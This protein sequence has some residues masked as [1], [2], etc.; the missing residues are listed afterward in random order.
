M[1]VY[2]KNIPGSTRLDADVCIIGGGAAG[3]TI[4]RSLDGG[5]LKVLLV[6]GGGSRETA[7]TTDLYTGVVEPFDTHE[8]LQEN[9]VRA[10][11]GSTVAWGGRCIPYDAI[12]FRRRDW[13]PHSGWPLSYDELLP[14]IRE[15]VGVCEA[16]R[17]EFDA[18]AAFPGTQAEILAGIDGD[19]MHSWP[20]ERW[21]PPTNF[22]TRYGQGFN[23]SRNVTVVLEGHVVRL[24]VNSTGSAVTHAVVASAP[25]RVFEVRAATFVLAAGG[26]EN[27]RLLLASNDVIP[28]GLGNGHDLVGRFYQSHRFGVC[29]EAVLRDPMRN[30]VY[31]FE[32]DSDGVYC[33]RRFRLSDTAQEQHRI[34]NAIA[35]FARP[36]A[37]A[38]VHRNA[39]TSSVYLAKT[40]M[41]A[42][43]RGPI[44][45]AQHL[46]RERSILTQHAKVVMS[47]GIRSAP[48]LWSLAVARFGGARRL[49]SILPP[50]R[51]NHFHL[52][53]QTEHAPN[54]ESRVA[55]ADERDALGMR[56]LSVHVAFS[57]V[58]FDTVRQ[59]Y[60]VFA[61]RFAASGAGTFSYSDDALEQQL[62]ATGQGFNSNAHHIGTTRMADIPSNGVVDRDCR[63]HGMQNLFVS[64]S[65]V[66][67]TSGHANPTLMIVALALRLAH[68]LKRPL[69]NA[70]AANA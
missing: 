10:W 40:V 33:R 57:P 26:L 54:P 66:F 30:F 28:T 12:D 51:F 19:D 36:G 6:A 43:K 20:L 29:G 41:N 44:R 32:R 58:D 11:G 21:S 2:A 13:I 59:L 1:L 45:M 5:P 55:L 22:A 38:A 24:A 16:G 49:P 23:R 18:R 35:F 3:I 8:P 62:D 52:Y 39:I 67:P 34:G 14:Y 46:V 9:R 37:G 4:A 47:D 50:R 64:G 70:A 56:R 27:P 63:V 60:R 7:F 61:R 53:Y 15:A 65:S 69:R 31:E 42:A 17:P 25:N 68:L 48:D